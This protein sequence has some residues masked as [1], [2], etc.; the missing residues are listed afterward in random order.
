VS[1][2]S[3]K[4]AIYVVDGT[5]VTNVSDINMDD[6]ASVSVLKYPYLNPYETIG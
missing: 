5:I 3:D 1:G 6:V 4:G 2:F